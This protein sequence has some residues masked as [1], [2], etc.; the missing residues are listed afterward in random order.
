MPGCSSMLLLRPIEVPWLYER[1]GFAVVGTVPG[2]FAH[3]GARDD[4]HRVVLRHQRP[5]ASAATMPTV[6]TIDVPIS[7]F[8][9]SE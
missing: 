5:A 1:L 7:P 8:T 3:P 4:G 9:D 6:D 2:A